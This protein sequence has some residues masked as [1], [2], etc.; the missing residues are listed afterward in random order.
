[1]ANKIIKEALLLILE[2]FNKLFSHSLPMLFMPRLI[3]IVM[4][5]MV[6]GTLGHFWAQGELK[7]FKDFLDWSTSQW[8]GGVLLAGSLV[9]L[10]LLSL[11][12]VPGVELGL[13]L[14]CVFG[15][16][17][18]L[19][20]YFATVGGLMLAF[21]VGQHLSK[22]RITV[23]SERLG[24]TLHVKNQN[25]GIENFPEQF[26]LGGIFL[27]WPWIG[28]YFNRYR[29]LALALIFNLPG[30]YLLG[31]GGGIALV[32]GLTRQYRWPG[33]LL[34]IILATAPVPILVWFGFIQLEV[35]LQLQ[36]TTP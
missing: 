4:L 8:G 36:T 1:M 19:P 28:R 31:G 16:K 18:I 21:T 29:H 11:P 33:F 9:Y 25:S 7:E 5:L 17:G 27:K 24:I 32:C 12:F 13:L 30:N 3:L 15:Q 6:L 22:E 20:I 35:W 34:T 2:K 26:A 23:W 14:M 10:L